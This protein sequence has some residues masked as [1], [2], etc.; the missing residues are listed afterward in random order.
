MKSITDFADIH[1]HNRNAGDDAIVS[2]NYCD[3]V[4]ARGYYSIGLHPW[5]TDL[6]REALERAIGEVK[7]K[8]SGERVIAIGECGIDLLRGADADTQTDIFRRHVAISEAV[9][10][11]LIIHAVR[12]FDRLLALRKELRPQQLWIIHGFRGKAALARQLLDAGFALSY[13][14]KF[15]PESVAITP[16]DRLFTETDES[17]LPIADIRRNIIAAKERH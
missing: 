12:S 15:N 9:S 7:A 1:S 5:H 8:A 6:G 14:E 10:K 17:T 4:P 13:G 3:A 11:P 16:A 2:L